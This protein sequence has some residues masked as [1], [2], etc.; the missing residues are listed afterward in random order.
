MLTAKKP[1]RGIAALLII[2]LIACFL[3]GA[4]TALLLYS[5]LGL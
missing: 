2:K 5:V 4:M 3:A 1:V